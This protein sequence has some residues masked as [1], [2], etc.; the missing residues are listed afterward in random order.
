[1]TKHFKLVDNRRKRLHFK[2]TVCMGLNKTLNKYY[3][4]KDPSL[5]VLTQIYQVSVERLTPLNYSRV[6][7]AF[8]FTYSCVCIP[9]LC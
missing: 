9:W 6:Y 5:V 3:I 8:S 4:K 7:S 2:I 1:M